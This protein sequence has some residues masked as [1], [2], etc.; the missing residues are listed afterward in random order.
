MKFFSTQTL[1]NLV[2]T[3]MLVSAAGAQAQNYPSRDITF[4]V[5]YGTG[6][7]TDPI[8]RKFSE[9]LSKILG[10]TINVQNKPGG[11]A[12]IGVGS[13]VRAEPDGY[14][15]GLGTNSSLLYQP[16]INKGLPYKTPEDYQPIV[17][18]VDLPA[19]LVVRADAPW[20]NFDEFMAD[21]KMNPGKIRASNSGNGTTDDLVLKQ[22][23]K[24]AG[25][26]IAPVPFSGG[27]GEAMIALLGGRVEASVSRAINASSF[28]KAGKLRVLAV[29]KK[30]AYDVFPEA[31]P[32]GDTY[33]ATLPALYVVIAPK[34]LP[35]SVMDKLVAGSMKAVQTE[36]F[37][38]FARDNGYVAEASGPEALKAELVQQSKLFADFTDKGIR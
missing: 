23:N 37:L 16:L 18:L 2:A 7:S 27:G 33:D 19:I 34:G 12:T 15:I 17:K 24:V 30:G 21:V 5:P 1:K 28:V 13:I 32:I 26:K 6:G 3:A 38:K 9:E 11:S 4:I 25:V 35:K 31:T 8:S 10:A 29:F 14:T 22:L 36:S 20:K